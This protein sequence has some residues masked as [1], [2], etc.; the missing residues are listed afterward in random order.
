MAANSPGFF[1]PK[2]FKFGPFFKGWAPGRSFPILQVLSD[3]DRN[4]AKRD[5][6]SGLNLALIAFPQSMAYA[7]IAGL[8]IHYGI[9]GSIIASFVGPLFTRSRFIVLGPTNATAVMLMSSFIALSATD[10]MKLQLLPLLL[11]MVGLFLI[12][13]AYLRA[14]TL[15]QYVSSS[16]VTGYITASALLIMVNQI[17]IVLGFSFAEG[18]TTFFG[19]CHETL[20]QMGQTHWP[21]LLVGLLTFGIY[22]LLNRSLPFLPNV[23]LTLGVISLLCWLLGE[24]FGLGLGIRAFAPF[25]VGDWRFTPPLVNFSGINQ[26]APVAMAIAF[27][28]VL[29]GISIGKS[30]A[31]RAGERL[32]PNREMMSMGMANIACGFFSGM[33]ASGSLTRSALN[34]NT[35]GAT[36]M[37]SVFSS[38]LCLLAAFLVGPLIA[39]LPKTALSVVVICLG[40]SLINFHQIRIVIKT[41]PADGVVF[42]ATFLAAL[43]FR[44]DTA[45][46][47]GT[48]IAIISFLHK[49]STPELVEYGYN[50]EGHLTV[51]AGD[52]HRT[53]KEISIVHVEGYLFFG[54]AELFRDQMRR[55]C[56]EPHLKIVILK[57][58]N[59]Y[60]WDATSAMA[61][62]ELIHYMREHDRV[63]LISEVREETYRIFEKSGVLAVVGP[64]AVLRDDDQNPNLS[65]ALAVRKARDLL[66]DQKS[67]V[68]IFA[69]PERP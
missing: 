47:F 51:L 14:A 54:A 57:M 1:E 15:I 53:Q 38:G 43:L 13:G 68:S 60:H 21:T 31:A 7:L 50:Q 34:W 40:F 46:F 52:C 27:L 44:L 25:G 19:I 59:A 4:K 42:F 29:E 3:Y 58:R 5:L 2:R 17:H 18:T 23:A 69:G 41:T 48:G 55:V 8:P 45:I 16:V 66:G 6:R 56:R 12:V 65:T 20:V 61:L 39:Y 32:N 26:L 9:F 10:A 63:L 22:V 28:S 67:R 64:D 11:L 36:P 62:E 33:S 30:L 37:A 49:A 24:V 35:G